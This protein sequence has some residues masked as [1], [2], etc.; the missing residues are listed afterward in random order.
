MQVAAHGDG[1]AAVNEYDC[2]L[3]EHV[4]GNRPDDS[5][6]VRAQVLEII[7]SDPGLQQTELVFLGLFGRCGYATVGCNGVCL[8]GRG[9]LGMCWAGGVQCWPKACHRECMRVPPTCRCCA[10]AGSPRIRQPVVG[11]T[12]VHIRPTEAV[13]TR[14]CMACLV[15]CCPRRT[16]WKSCNM[17]LVCPA[18]RAVCWSSLL[19]VLRLQMPW[20]SAAHWWICWRPGRQHWQQHWRAHSLSCAQP[21]GR[22]KPVFRLLC[23]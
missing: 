20:L 9:L 16:Q 17:L 13:V 18:G 5:H 1:R 4:F 11:C 14:L 22:V 15:C 10:A 19:M 12:S 6:K 23:R 7:A 3:L 21:S 2:L 8:L